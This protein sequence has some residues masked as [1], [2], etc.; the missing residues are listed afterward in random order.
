MHIVDGITYADEQ[1]DVISVKSVR[2]TA[3][4]QLIVEFVDETIKLFDFKPLL[5]LPCYQPLKNID[6]FSKAYV[7]YGVVTWDNGEIDIA[8]ETLYI[9]GVADMNGYSEIRK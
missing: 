6:V 4:F 1:K 9:N 5:D 3:D 2:T 8:P 7:D